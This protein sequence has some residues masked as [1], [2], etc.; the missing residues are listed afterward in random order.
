MS[1]LECAREMVREQLLANTAPGVLGAGIDPTIGDG[2]LIVFFSDEAVAKPFLREL[3]G[4]ELFPLVKLVSGQRLS[5]R[6]LQSCSPPITLLRRLL[7]W[8]RRIRTA[9]VPCSSTIFPIEGD[10][11]RLGCFVKLNAGAVVALTVGHIFLYRDPNDSDT[12]LV[13]ACNEFGICDEDDP[14]GAALDFS[15]LNAVV[16]SVDG[17]IFLPALIP[18]E[19]PMKR[20]IVQLTELAGVEGKIAQNL[21]RITYPGVVLDS[22]GIIKYEIFDGTVLKEF[23]FDGQIFLKS[24]SGKFGI[25]SDSGVLIV[26]G[27]TVGNVVEGSILGVYSWTTFDN[28]YHFAVPMHECFREFKISSVYNA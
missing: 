23:L 18:K 5:A 21:A 25:Q 12:N 8:F 27:E 17:A 26:L 28:L 13:F 4:G 10:K 2:R 19:S 6:R 24:S 20:A 22:K 15:S 14:I 1:D 7:S 9:P 11:G 3:L 16:N